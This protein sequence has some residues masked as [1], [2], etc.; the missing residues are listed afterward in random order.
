M[1]TISV[2]KTSSQGIVISKAYLV[3]KPDL[4][5]RIDPVAGTEIELELH[6]FDQAQQRAVQQLEILAVDSDIFEAHLMLAQDEMLKDAIYEKTRNGTNIEQ[7]LSETI[8]EFV[9]IFNNMDDEYMRERAADIKDIGMRFMKLLKGVEDNSI[10]DIREEVI[11]IAEDLTPS[12]TAVMNFNY[13]KGFITESGGVTS[14]VSIIAKNKGIPALVGVKDIMQ[15]VDNG[16]QIIL[17]ASEGSIILNPDEETLRIFEEKRKEHLK[18]QRHLEEISNLPCITSDGKTI[19]LCVNVGNSEEINQAIEYHVDGIG[20]FRSEF[21]YM[22]NTHFP[23][24]DE[25]FDAYK[26]AAQA[27]KGEVIIRTLDIGGDKVLPYYRFEKEENPFLGWRGIRISLDMKEIFKV[28]LRAILRASHYGMIKIMFPMIISIEEFLQAKELLKECQLELKNEGIP[29]NEIIE[30]GIMV[31]TPACVMN[32]EDFAKVADFFSIGTNDLT[33]YM[34]GVDRGNTKIAEL[35]NS[36]HPAVIRSINRVVKA[37]HK[38][39]RKVGMCGEFASDP[40]AI[41]ILLGMGLDEF[42]MSAKSIA[43]VKDIL[44]RLDS[45]EAEKLAERVL[46]AETVN[47]IME[48][49]LEK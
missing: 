35:Y 27:C 21:L 24:E 5:P 4:T 46:V 11:I 22:D 18:Y 25:Q 38:Y 43:M 17:D 6:R 3:K 12:D 29:F 28:Q 41:Q 32:V 19:E 13:V 10:A 9:I 40:K 33:Q 42:S 1:K 44:R 36:F 15:L 14:H 34:L 48:L 8:E 39:N 20:L 26:K 23:T 7:A 30:T 37:G 49:L 45:K 31:E 47:E 2:K 16:D